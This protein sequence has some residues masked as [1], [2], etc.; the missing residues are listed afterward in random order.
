M[1]PP[2][3]P[4]SLG[5]SWLPSWSRLLNGS[6]KSRLTRRQHLRSCALGLGAWLKPLSSL[7]RESSISM[8]TYVYKRV[9]KLEIKAD[10]HRP[11]DGQ[12]SVVIW[13]H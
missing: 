6:M 2:P 11:D 13:V 9:G 12:S 5:D 10:I 7:V 8:R 1:R 3:G 4:S